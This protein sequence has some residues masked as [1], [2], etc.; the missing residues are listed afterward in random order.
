MFAIYAH[1]QTNLYKIDNGGSGLSQIT[2]EDQISAAV[3]IGIDPGTLSGTPVAIV[4]SNITYQTTTPPSALIGVGNVVPGTTLST[5]ISPY[6]LMCIRVDN[7]T[8]HNALGTDF[9]VDGNGNV[10]IGT[11]SPTN[12]LD[13]AGS[14]TIEGG[15]EVVQDVLVG[16]NTDLFGTLYTYG[17]ASFNNDLE[18]DGDSYLYGTS[19]TGGAATF[20]STVAITG[21][22]TLAGTL[23]VTGNTTVGGSL[24]IGTVSSTPSGYNLYVQNGIITEKAKV[25]VSGSSEWSDYVFDKD[26]KLPDLNQVKEYIAKNHHLPGVPSADDVICDGIDLGSMDATLLKKI[27]ELTLYVLQ[28]KKDNETMKAQLNNLQK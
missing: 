3:G 17:D 9:V 20:A 5:A 6:S 2:R 25:A 26:Y 10:G 21:N 7:T 19:Y 13:V 16:G 22:T 12:M 8:A 1:A 27:E 11:A 15:M 24:V 18:V 14:A 4:V 28:L 23:A